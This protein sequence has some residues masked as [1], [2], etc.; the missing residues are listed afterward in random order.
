MSKLNIYNTSGDLY[1]ID[2]NYK[3]ITM[4]PKESEQYYE[5]FSNSKYEINT[6]SFEHKKLFYIVNL[7][8]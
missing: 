5:G 4:T 1:Q 6:T 3:N 7:I 8:F 2:D